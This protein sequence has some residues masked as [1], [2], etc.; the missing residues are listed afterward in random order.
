MQIAVLA[1]VFVC[2]MQDTA[3]F[4]VNV[5]TTTNIYDKYVSKPCVAIVL[6]RNT[7]YLPSRHLGFAQALRMNYIATMY[8]SVTEQR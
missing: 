5:Y 4:F 1:Y 3:G 7:I 6:N 2:W 8:Q